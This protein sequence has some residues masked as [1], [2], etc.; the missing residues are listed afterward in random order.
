MSNSIHLN[1]CLNKGTD[2]FKTSK[3]KQ[4]YFPYITLFYSAY[5]GRILVKHS[6]ECMKTL[7]T[8]SM[9]A[10]SRELH[11][12]NKCVH[13][14]TR[15]THTFYNACSKTQLWDPSCGSPKIAVTGVDV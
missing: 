6:H 10:Q 2:S 8:H 7:Y 9:F 1:C 13:Q 5:Q 15:K 4:S 3:S 11:N 14:F 12:L